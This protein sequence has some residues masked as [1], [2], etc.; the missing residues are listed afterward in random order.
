MGKK[1]ENAL[2]VAPDMWQ[3]VNGEIH[4]TGSIC[5]S[6]EEVYFPKKEIAVCSCCQGEDLR[7]I[8]LSRVGHIVSWTVVHQP[9]AGG[10]YKGPVPFIY[11]IV[12][13]PEKVHVQGHLIGIDADK[14]EIG[15]RVQTVLDLL[16]EDEGSQVVT[17]KF[18][19]AEEGKQH[20]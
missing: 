3:E 20:A 4:L 2:P 9:P 15:L 1:W 18:A 6:C 13:L 7:E 12:E 10:F 16:Y 11:V 14:V 19:P 8:P 5:K 17:F